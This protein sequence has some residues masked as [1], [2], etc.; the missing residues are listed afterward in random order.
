MAKAFGRF[1]E[2]VHT[3]KHFVEVKQDLACL[4]ANI[5][6]QLS[7]SYRCLKS[8]INTRSPLHVDGCRFEMFLLTTDLQVCANILRRWKHN[9]LTRALSKWEDAHRRERYLRSVCQKIVIR[10]EQMHL[11][12]YRIE[13]VHLYSRPAQLLSRTCKRFCFSLL[14]NM[15][16]YHRRFEQWHETCRDRRRFDRV[17]FHTLWRKGQQAK[18]IAFED[19]LEHV[20][21]QKKNEA[22]DLIP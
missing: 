11:F 22:L 13:M 20:L 17:I 1:R 21:E 12:R 5:P 9:Q 6:S 19:W 18:A 15:C 14:T 8:F 2:A 10:W 7:R 4:Y 16:A 3:Q